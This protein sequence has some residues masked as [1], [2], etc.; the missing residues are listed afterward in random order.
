MMSVHLFERAE[1]E[2]EQDAALD[3][4]IDA[5][6]GWSRRVRLRRAQRAG[7]ERGA[8]LEECIHCLGVAYCDG[9]GGEVQLN[10]CFQVFSC[11]DLNGF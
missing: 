8:Q 2:T 10:P 5:P 7:F 6:A 1:T 9:T 11:H 4:G 3:P